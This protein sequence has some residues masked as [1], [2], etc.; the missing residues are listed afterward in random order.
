MAYSAISALPI[1]KLKLLHKKKLVGNTEMLKNVL[2]KY[3]FSDKVI[4]KLTVAAAVASS[5]SS[6]KCV[7]S[8][9][10]EAPGVDTVVETFIIID[11]TPPIHFYD[12]HGLYQALVHSLMRFFHMPPIVRFLLSYFTEIFPLLPPR[13]PDA[14]R[15]A[16]HQSKAT[17][18]RLFSPLRSETLANTHNPS[19]QFPGFRPYPLYLLATYCP[20][21]R[22]RRTLCTQSEVEEFFH[23][24]VTRPSRTPSQPSRPSLHSSSSARAFCAALC[25]ILPRNKI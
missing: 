22:N 13:R 1:E 23:P 4:G 2:D 11:P 6:S 15:L 21:P 20:A 9:G 16:T 19:A 5:S 10:V 7:V 14:G 3:A 25:Y 12:L 8:L 17:P 24:A 18:W